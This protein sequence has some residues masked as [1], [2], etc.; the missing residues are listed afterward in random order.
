MPYIKSYPLFQCPIGNALGDPGYTIFKSITM[1]GDVAVD[2]SGFAYFPNTV[3][4]FSS[5][6]APADLI[7]QSDGAPNPYNYDSNFTGVLNSAVGA[8]Y[9]WED[10]AASQPIQSWDEAYRRHNET[11]NYAMADGHAKSLHPAQTLFSNVA[12][13]NDNPT[14][15]AMAANPQGAGWFPPAP[16]GP[17][18]PT[19]DCS[20]FQYWDG[21]GGY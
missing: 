7:L 20:V 19:M 17:I 10:E 21:Q 8:C 4:S 1:N 15:A 18:S 2:L 6:A 5:A 13:F 3:V 14:A 16:A 12:W 11:A 9:A